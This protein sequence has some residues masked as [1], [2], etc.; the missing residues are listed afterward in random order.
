M[1]HCIY[2]SIWNLNRTTNRLAWFQS[3]VRY[4]LHR[5]PM[6]QNGSKALSALS[7]T[8]RCHS[9]IVNRPKST[10]A[11]I[12]YSTALAHASMIPR[13][14]RNLTTKYPIG[15][16]R[17]GQDHRPKPAHVCFHWQGVSG[18]APQQNFEQA[19][20]NLKAS[21]PSLLTLLTRIC[22]PPF[23]GAFSRSGVTPLGS[24]F[25]GVRCRSGD[26]RA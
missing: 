11:R 5:W 23:S 20:Q 15:P 9:D 21:F 2:L 12:A 16:A 19:S 3:M 25:Q 1:K 26:N 6:F 7:P 17:I 10:T 14:I 24:E 4:S 13:T 18:H 8:E 22:L